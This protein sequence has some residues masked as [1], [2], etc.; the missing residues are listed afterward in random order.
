M[1]KKG[2][3][4][5]K[6]Q[7]KSD[8]VRPHRPQQYEYYLLIVC[9][10]EKTEPYYF[11]KFK[12]LFPEKTLYLK[13]VGTGTNSKGVVEQA[14]IAR[15]EIKDSIRK[16]VD[17]V[18]A[19]FDKDD[20]DLSPGNRRRFEEAFEIAD[21]EEIKIAYSNEAFE[22]WLLL[23]FRGVSVNDPIPRKDI[24]NYLQ[25]CISKSTHHEDFEYIHGDKE[26]VDI[27]VASGNENKAIERAEKLIELHKEA[28]NS[29]IE[30]NP[31][32]KVHLLIGRLRELIEYYSFE[33]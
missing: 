10:D 15:D 17:E 5:R 32:T 27:V 25:E 29:P 3:I 20:L 18:W 31:S 6:K 21:S 13:T 24:Y 33:G 30:A 22:L 1:A 26:V 14:A 19:V 12:D 28:G 2:R 7:A 11:E 4:S 16:T 23:H 8:I 9:E